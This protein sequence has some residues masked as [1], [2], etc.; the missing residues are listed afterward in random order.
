MGR[1]YDALTKSEREQW[2]GTAVESPAD[3]DAEPDETPEVFDFVRYS[4]NTPSAEQLKRI[5]RDTDAAARD[6]ATALK[7]GRGVQIGV[8]GID[9]HLVEFYECDPRASEE[10]HKLASNLISSARER[11]FKRLLIAS[12]RNGDGRTAVALNL[13]SALAHAKMRVLLIDADLQRPSV[14][15]LLGIG[16]EIG[17]SE[18]LARKLPAGDALIKIL[19]HG[20]VVL[21]SRERVDNAAEILASPDFS[22]MLAGF[23]G[24]FDF[25][26]FDS[27]PLLGSKDARLLVAL[28]GAA[29]LVIRPD[30]TTPAEL[31]RAIAPLTREKVAGVVLNRVA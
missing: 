27:S 22:E 21:P 28:T 12:A 10:Y 2:P 6:K 18:L 15:R 19:P 23:D 1:V 8:S 4:I 25:I 20:F 24:E 9:P 5:R 30:K 13:S 7:P 29:L 14:L 11:G 3:L 26:L 16:S 17:I 31:G